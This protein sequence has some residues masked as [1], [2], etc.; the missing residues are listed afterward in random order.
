MR[1]ATIIVAL[2][3]TSIV[4]ITKTFG[5][6]R[7]EVPLTFTDGVSTHILHF[8]ILP[9]G[10][11]CIDESD[12]I[13]GHG[14]SY[15]P[16]APPGGVFDARFICPHS[17][18]GLSCFDQGSPNDYRASASPTQRDTFRVSCQVGSGTALHVSWPAGLSF[19][20][21]ELWLDSDNGSLH[22]INM[23]TDTSVELSGYLVRFR[24]HA[25][26]PHEGHYPLEIGNRWEYWT[27]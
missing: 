16:P 5:Q 26:G 22:W 20:F 6:P 13:H 8:G 24:I 12:T 25:S 9:G 18:C 19:Y 15:L 4:T 27:C 2:V 1:T 10:H 17:R 3:I 11:F 21:D 14:E 23:L 7:F